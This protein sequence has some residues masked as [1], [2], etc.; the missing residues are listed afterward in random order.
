MKSLNS[1]NP[2][3]HPKPQSGINM[4]DLMMWLVIAALLLA[5]AIQGISYYQKAAYLYQMQSDLDG[6]G[7][8]VMA[9]ATMSE[10]GKIDKETAKE[11]TADSKWSKDIYHVVEVAGDGLPYLRASHPVVDH[12]DAVYL[13]KDCGTLRVGVNLIPKSGVP[14]C[15]IAPET[16]P[17]DRDGIE[18]VNN[19]LIGWNGITASGDAMRVFGGDYNGY[20]YTSANGGVSWVRHTEPGKGIWRGVSS[21]HDGR[22]LAAAVEGG[23]LHISRDYG[24]TWETVYA[25]GVGGTDAVGSSKW[26]NIT[27]SDDGQRIALGIGGPGH[28]WTSADS[29]KTWTEQLGSPLAEWRGMTSSADGSTIIAGSWGGFLH[30]SRDYGVTWTKTTAG[31]GPA[32]TWHGMG[33]SDDGQIM[34]AGWKGNEVHRST[35]GGVTWTKVLSPSTASGTKAWHAVAVSGD[36]ETVVAAQHGGVIFV[37]KDGG[38]TW[39][40]GSDTQIWYNIA[41]SNDGNTIIIGATGKSLTIGYVH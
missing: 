24:E 37:S 26:Y 4:V 34:F 33:M 6:A 21:S 7:A 41:M 14:E 12:K 35:D 2:F 29:G 25:I 9:S 15:G 40:T 38:D 28:I 11:S 3:R 20:L 32:G 10:T 23:Y 8:R 16:L 5:T 36:G 27:I 39:A 1:H 22:V 19:D 17:A 18:M 31:G 30:I 13:F